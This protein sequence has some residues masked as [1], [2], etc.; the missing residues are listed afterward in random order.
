LESLV[1]EAKEAIPSSKIFGSR[2]FS[3]A[4]FPRNLVEDLRAASALEIAD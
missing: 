1:S 3:F 4:L 2:E